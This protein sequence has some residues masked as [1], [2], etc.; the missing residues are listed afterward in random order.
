VNGDKAEAALMISMR[1]RPIH[2]WYFFIY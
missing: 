1:L 2:L